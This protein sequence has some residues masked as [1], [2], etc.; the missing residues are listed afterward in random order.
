MP[1]LEKPEGRGKG[2]PFIPRITIT[3]LGHTVKQ[4]L[5]TK[6][7]PDEERF[8]KQVGISWPKYFQS[9]LALVIILCKMTKS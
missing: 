2:I 1:L 8:Q 7:H 3:I 4:H 9:I 5:V 6:C